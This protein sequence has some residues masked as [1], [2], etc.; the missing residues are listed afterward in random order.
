[1]RA[2]RP[3]CGDRRAR[4]LA[5]GL[6]LASALGPVA[7]CRDQA[8][9]RHSDCDP[10]LVCS[11]LGACVAPVEPDGGDLGDAGDTPDAMTDA[12]VDAVADA[13][14]P[15]AA[16][17]DATG[18][19]PDAA[20]DAAVDAATD[21]AIDAVPRTLESPY[22]APGEPIMSPPPSTTTRGRAGPR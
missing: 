2:E 13:G 22:S 4:L 10:G 9:V 16:T 8:C 14:T 12:Q 21:A 11:P 19:A 20:V 3:G 6:A 18:D 5:L 7:G 17:G 1:M 15:D